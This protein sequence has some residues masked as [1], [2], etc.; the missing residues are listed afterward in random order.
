MN[1]LR[2]S[3]F[4]LLLAA[5]SA[6]A[7]VDPGLL[8]LVMPDAKVVSGIQVSQALASPFG[9]YILNQMQPGNQG[10][11]EFLAATGF[12]PRKDL[13]QIVVA[14]GNT[15]TNPHDALVLG[16]G[17]FALT[18]INT[19]AT[20]HGSVV[21][22]YK[23]VNIYT[24]P[25]QKSSGSLAFPDSTTAIAGEI[26][27]V[28]AAIDRDLAKAT[29]T[30]PLAQLSQTVSAAN[31]AWFATTSPL[32]DFVAGKLGNTDLGNVN[33][34]NL[35]QSVLQATGGVA[36]AASGVTLSADALTASPQ[37]AQSLVDVLKFVVSLI[38]SNAN[39]PKA[40]T[41]ASAATFTVV[42]STAHISLPI[43]EQ[44]AEQLLMPHSGAKARHAAIPQ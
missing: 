7:A 19:A 28:Q 34:T 13:V 3:G 20:S 6:M 25:D 14:T 37:N 2:T 26:S 29:F 22:Q 32:S 12:D 44:Q 33:S 30:G 4:A 43:P 16:R 23:G 40:T 41:L 31:Q 5:T 36:F 35:L 21:T 24:S 27:A 10:F 17:S 9:Q 39:D 15:S 18:Q 11:Q 1:T 38:Q 8:N 42:G